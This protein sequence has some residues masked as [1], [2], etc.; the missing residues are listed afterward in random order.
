MTDTI[1]VAAPF[2]VA[3][4]QA[5]PEILPSPDRLIYDTTAPKQLGNVYPSWTQLLIVANLYQGP[6]TIY[7]ANGSVIPVGS[8]SMPDDWYLVSDE[9]GFSVPS[10][11][12]FSNTPIGITSECQAAIVFEESAGGNTFVLSNP[13][14]VIQNVEL[15]LG[16][17][18]NLVNGASNND[19]R[20]INAQ[21]T[22]S[23]QALMSGT[24]N[25]VTALQ[26]TTLA[27]NVLPS[28]MTIKYDSTSNVG[29][30]NGNTGTEI[31]GGG[32]AT[33]IPS[34][35]FR[36]GGVASGNVYVTEA[37]L[38]T[39]TQSFNG[40]PYTIFFDLS[41]VSRTYTFTTVGALG[42]AENGTWTDGGLG[43]TL[44]FVN[45]TTLTDH[46]NLEGSLRVIQDQAA[47]VVT[48]ASDA[49]R[50]LRGSSN[51]RTT[52][53]AGKGHWCTSNGN[54]L[55][56]VGKDEAFLICPSLAPIMYVNTGALTIV[57]AD[58]SVMQSVVTD[59]VDYV[60]VSPGAY[61]A[62]VNNLARLT[63]A[64]LLTDL[65][66]DGPASIPAGG[67]NEG[68]SMISSGALYISNGT[69]WVE[70]GGGATIGPGP[71]GALQTGALTF[72]TT[73][74]S[75]I[76]A[77]LRTTP[78][79]INLAAYTSPFDGL[80]LCVTNAG[81]NAVSISGAQVIN[82][83]SGMYQDATVTPVQISPNGTAFTL[84]YDA[85]MSAALG[86]PAWSWA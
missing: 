46:P 54:I 63:I 24:S 66:G 61:A 57:A 51:I 40:A 84:Y 48:Q 20:L 38:A 86:K 35:V 16:T 3:P 65:Q 70:Q 28:S 68:Q 78:A 76:F 45:G 32:A 26:Q 2:D 13:L 17:N 14:L 29:S 47:T 41:L 8:Y 39:A 36:P 9:N 43:Y 6:V 33:T 73:Q 49:I 75:T 42:L 67:A 72:S 5:F 4:G 1:T 53:V 60:V 27:N 22:T 62:G 58:S 55:T 82:P 71:S 25:T 15:V 10:G 80:A 18:G 31:G 56:I 83:Q 21:V 74:S 50:Y 59:A 81:A 34:V 44:N 7:V 77:D 64:G 11:V 23:G 79:S 85:A 19:M 37:A 12:R 30:Q 69:S 52:A